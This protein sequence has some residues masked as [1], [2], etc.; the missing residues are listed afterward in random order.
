MRGAVSKGDAR[1]AADFFTSMQAP[2]GGFVAHA[3]APEADLLS[4]F[5][6]LVSLSVLGALGRADLPAVAR[7]ARSLAVPAGG[8]RA[9]ASDA[10]ADVEYTYYGLAAAALLKLHAADRAR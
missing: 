1:A 7:F 5:T 9:S 2:G 6:A 3:R 8:F 4:T 10:E